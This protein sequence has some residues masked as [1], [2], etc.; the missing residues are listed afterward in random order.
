MKKDLK[1]KKELWKFKSFTM[2]KY[3]LQKKNPLKEIIILQDII[4]L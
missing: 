4:T 1:A 2:Q 3:D